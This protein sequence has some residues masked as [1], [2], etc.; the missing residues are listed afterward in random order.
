MNQNVEYQYG[1]EIEKKIIDFLGLI[2][3]SK[4]NNINLDIDAWDENEFSY[5]IKCQHTALK[6]GNLAFELSTKNANGSCSKSWYYTGKS[7]DYLIVVG[8]VLYGI[9]R[10]HLHEYI[11]KSG[12][13][14]LT[15][16]SLKIQQSQKDIG[17]SHI[18]ASIGLISI[19]RLKQEGLI[20]VEW[21]LP[22]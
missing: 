8:N 22:F 2:P 17:H 3:S 9:D 20:S 10:R 6:T 4:E 18:N 13:D 16:L 15:S 7:D 14:R 11:R 5:S 21:N 19:K 1:I 12:W